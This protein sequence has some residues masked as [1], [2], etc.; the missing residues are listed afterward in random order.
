MDLRC[1]VSEF[2]G[3]RW[4]SVVSQVEQPPETECMSTDVDGHGGSPTI[5]N[6]IREI[7]CEDTFV[8]AMPTTQFHRHKSSAV[9]VFGLKMFGDGC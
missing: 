5:P 9:L 1:Q 3:F 8:L 4:F 7:L 2:P 6:R